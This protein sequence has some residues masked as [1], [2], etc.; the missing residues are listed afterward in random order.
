V[1]LATLNATK[2]PLSGDVS[3]AFGFSLLLTG[4][5]LGAQGSMI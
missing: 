1:N 3:L 4:L 5:L 2:H